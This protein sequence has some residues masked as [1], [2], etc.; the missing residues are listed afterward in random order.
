MAH[1][2]ELIGDYSHQ[3]IGLLENGYTLEQAK[4]KLAQDQA[5]S[6]EY[7][8]KYQE[9]VDKLPTWARIA[10]TIQDTVGMVYG[11]KAAGVGLGSLASKI[12]MKGAERAAKFSEGWRTADLNLEPISIGVY[13]TQ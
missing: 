12:S 10:M 13:S 1:Y 9:A 7:A 5:E 11:A 6:V 4:A 3:W 2:A 8:R